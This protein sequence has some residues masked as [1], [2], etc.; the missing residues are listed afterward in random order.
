MVLRALGLG[1]LLTALPALR[2]LADAFPGHRLVLAAPAVFAPLAWLSGALDRVADTAP[3]QPLDRS[4]H[5]P[6]VAV[7]LHGRGPQSHRVLLATRPGRLI[8]FAHPD[9]PD[10][11]GSPPWAAAEHEVA[12]WCRLLQS[13]GIPADPSRLDLLAPGTPPPWAAAEGATVIHPGAASGARR[14]PVD[15]WAAIAGAA[16]AAGHRVVVTGRAA[17]AGLGAD[18]AARSGLSPDSVLAGRTDLLGV[19]A[20]VAAAGRVVCGDTGVAHLA[21]ALG[22]PSVVLFGPVP[23]SEWGPPPDRPSHVAL[24]AGRRGDPHAPD[25]DPGLLRISVEDVLAALDGLPPPARSGAGSRPAT[26]NR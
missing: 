19:A 22:T 1:D 7:N 17:E 14:W 26:P 10:S 5:R 2:A 20:V 4:L 24:W 16:A 12:R 13:S 18:V 6:D 3:L 11:A 25:P 15:R 8:A 9:V 21:T 23:P